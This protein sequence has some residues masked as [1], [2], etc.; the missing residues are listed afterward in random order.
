[1]KI[2]PL[3]L[4][5]I[6]SPLTSHIS[7]IQAQTAQDSTMNQTVRLERDFSPIVQQKNKIDR[8]P[9]LQEVQQKKNTATL[10]NWQ[11]ESVRSS[12]IGIV[13]AGQVV[14]ERKEEQSGYVQFSAGNYWN[15]DLR[16]GATLDEFSVD[17]KGFYTKS[18]LE[19]PYPVLNG[20]ELEDQKWDNMLMRGDI[21]GTWSHTCGNEAQLEAHVGARGSVVKTFNYQI[22]GGTT[23]TL[24]KVVDEATKQRWGQ[25]CGD[26]SYETNDFKLF[27]GYDFTHLTPSDSLPCD[28]R[29]NTIQFRGTYGI[30][31]QDNWQ[32]SADLDMSGVFGKEESYFTIHPTLHFSYIP[33]LNTWKRIY[34]DLGFGS[35]H[36]ALMDVMNRVPLA[37]ILEEYK[38]STDVCDLHIG[39]EDNDQGY[40]RWG[41]EIQWSYVKDALCSVV[42]PAFLT[43]FDG[44]YLGILQDDSYVFGFKANVDYEYSRYFGIKAGMDLK[45]YSCKEAGM[46]DPHFKLNTHILSNPG[47]V[48]M[49]LGFDLGASRKIQCYDLE[50]IADLNYSILWQCNDN[51]NVFASA[52]NILNKQY[53]LWPGVPAQGFNVHAGFTWVF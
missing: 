4:A 20:T 51:L 16:A 50:A 3:V 26:I 43:G 6:F 7:T 14:A 48:K 36:E 28:W 44:Q 10:A 22:Y 25:I 2:Y 45:T 38:N 30:Y 35:R 15:A 37:Y 13:P 49:D 33:E 53:Q 17:A 42:Y 27:L 5:T 21:L 1:M 46:G 8:Q 31:D 19:L 23:D 12:E 11:V 24:S 29:S 18:S 39:Y 52:R 34:A 41:A 9:A 32:A 47:K 40:L